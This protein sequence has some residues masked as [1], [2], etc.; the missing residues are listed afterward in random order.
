[1]SRSYTF[2]PEIAKQADYTRRY[3]ERPGPYSGQFTAAWYEQSKTGAE[4]IKFKFVADD[5]SQANNLAVYTHRG[6]GEK[7][8]G[9]S[10]IQKIMACMRINSLHTRPDTVELF[11]YH[12]RK[13]VKQPRDIYPAL[14]GPIGLV[15]ITEDYETQNG[16]KT[17]VIIR[18]AFEPQS[19]LM[20]EEIANGIEAP[21]AL[22]KLIH[23]ISEKG[24]WYKSKTESA[25]PSAPQRQT[26][27]ESEFELDDI[28]F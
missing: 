20:A 2:E 10:L 6:N 19:R 21:A 11:D 25:A 18:S 7:L 17:Q 16:T 12:S 3:I 28:P 22:D 23:H 26:Q 15:L 27:P 14:R 9:Y 5:R 13:M 4:C 8:P 1:M 24:E